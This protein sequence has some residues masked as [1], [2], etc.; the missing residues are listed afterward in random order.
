M[1]DELELQ[2]YALKLRDQKN[3]WRGWLWGASCGVAFVLVVYL[4]FY[5]G[6]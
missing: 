6:A 2:M 3:F 4:F 1:V 5:A